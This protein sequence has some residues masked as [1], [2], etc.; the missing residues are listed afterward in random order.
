MEAGADFIAPYF[1]RMENMDIDPREVIS[2][3]AD[4]IEK[5]NYNSKILAA[6]LKNIGQVND[7]FACGAQTATVAPEILQDALKMSA[8]QKAVDD[9]TADWKAIYG[10]VSIVDLV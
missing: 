1:N 6:S 9:F 4:M 5:Y 10:D 8:I 7:S 3:F 2:T